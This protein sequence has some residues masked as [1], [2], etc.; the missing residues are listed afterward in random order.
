MMAATPIAAR[1]AANDVIMKMGHIGTV[2]AM[3]VNGS[4]DAAQPNSFPSNIDEKEMFRKA[5]SNPM[6]RAELEAMIY[7]REKRVFLIDSDIAACR[8]FSVNAMVTFQ[9][10]RNVE[11]AIKEYQEEYWYSRFNNIAKRVMQF[12]FK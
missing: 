8:S 6:M 9:R 7:E 10:Q 2:G 3:N 4:S 5:F 1:G 12:G 11:R